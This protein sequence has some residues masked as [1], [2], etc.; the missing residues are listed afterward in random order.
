MQTTVPR[1][2][3]LSKLLGLLLMIPR[4]AIVLALALMTLLALAVE[5]I[6]DRFSDDEYLA[7]NGE[8]RERW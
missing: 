5:G 3:L 4:L 7:G 1:V 8:P 6:Y 2:S